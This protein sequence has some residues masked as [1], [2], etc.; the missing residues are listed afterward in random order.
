M[1]ERD[2]VDKIARLARLELSDEEAALMGKQLGSILDYIAELSQVDTTGVEPLAHCLPMQNVFR[3][4]RVEPGLGTEGALA[5]APKR[6]GD[7]FSVPTI[8]ET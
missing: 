8:L 3:E 2:Q 5:N 7:F 1:F 6:V 4:D